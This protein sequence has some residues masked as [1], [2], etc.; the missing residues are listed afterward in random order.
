MC[1][2]VTETI[3]NLFVSL[4][5]DRTRETIKSGWK[6]VGFFKLWHRSLLDIYKL[7]FRQEEATS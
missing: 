3:Q 7:S 6:L 5:G 2:L 4:Y 1:G